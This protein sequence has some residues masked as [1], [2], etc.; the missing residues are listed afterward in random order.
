[1]M[2]W[3]D[4]MIVMI[5]LFA[6]GW[7][8]FKTQSYVK[9]VADFLA[10]GRVAGRYVICVAGGE[11]GL[12]LISVIAL[13]EYYYKT[14]LS[15][16]FWS[17]ISIPVSLIMT[18]T[19]FIIYRYRQTRVMTVAQFFEVRYS[20]RFRIF[21][22]LLAF[23]S[24]VVNYALFPAVAG[25]FLVY[26][27]G[28]PDYISLLGIS[29]SVYGLVMAV[30]LG[31]ALMV[32]LTGGQ[33]MTMVTDCVQ[34]IFSYFG[35][36][37][38][39][40]AI[41]MLFRLDQI[42]DVILTRPAGESFIDP[43]DTSS[44]TE[45]NLLYIFIGIFGSIYS[46]MSWQGSQ[47]YNCAA[48]S[49]H[50]QK[51]GGV[52]SAW[53][54]GF[55]YLTIMLLVVAAFTYLN[56]PDFATGSKQIHSELAARINLDSIS[57]TSTIRNQMLVPVAL[58]HILPIGVSGVF[59]AIMMFLMISTDTTYLHSWGS[60]F[61]QDVILPLRK[62]ELKPEKQLLMLRLTIVGVAMFAWI[63][64][65][66]FGQFTYILMFFAI[67]GTVYMGGAGAV[68]IGGLYWTRGKTAGAWAAMLIGA[69][70]GTSGFVTQKF[71]SSHIYPFW[72]DFSPASLELFKTKLEAYGA[73]LPF[74]NWKVAGDSFPL[75]GTEIGFATMLLAVTGYVFFSLCGKKEEF[76][77]DKMLHRGKYDLRHEHADGDA[78][79]AQQTGRGWVAKILGIDDEY[80]RGDRIL[81][82]SVFIWTM[83]S[84]VI[85]LVLLTL[86]LFVK[87]WS[88]DGW[89]NW[90]KYYTL[91]LSLLVCVIT[92]IW[93]TIGG[94]R[95]LLELFRS[96]K[97]VKR[98]DSDNGCVVNHMNVSDVVME[99]IITVEE[100]KGL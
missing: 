30:A 87:R 71:W 98:D 12:G 89:F 53:R 34:G 22:G 55:S 38:I 77:L 46:R 82:W 68:I 29:I 8:G 25:R 63:F 56:H 93:F 78:V 80:T 19:G 3:I 26:Y 57:A 92:S 81:A 35:Y 66:Y 54:S 32:V 50:E 75:S 39:V 41:L 4:W 37:V 96:L 70:V 85:F 27:C 48:K 9:G 49:P 21:T 60:I 52:L 45:F 79:A 44:F 84:F 17:S 58:K 62:R 16:G 23:I 15:L 1:M 64:S 67:T 47:G 20:R 69:V 18:L 100:D 65:Y 99:K 72:K 76:N 90:W 33:L 10:G 2:H 31:V 94:S 40:I 13:F 73:A 83:K 86:N 11:A 14:G 7:I 91:P 61:V 88:P 59:V 74:V 24:G 5:P 42:R 36:A 97:N 28:L 95:D 43:F 51:M 6:V